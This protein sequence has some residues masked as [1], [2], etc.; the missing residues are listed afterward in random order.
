MTNDSRSGIAGDENGLMSTGQVIWSSLVGVVWEGAAHS[1]FSICSGAELGVEQARED[2]GCSFTACH[3]LFGWGEVLRG[4]EGGDTKLGLGLTCSFPPGV[5]I[6][7]FQLGLSIFHILPPAQTSKSG[8]MFKAMLCRSWSEYGTEG[9]CRGG[10]Q[11][12]QS[13]SRRVVFV[14]SYFS[15]QHSSLFPTLVTS[16]PMPSGNMLLP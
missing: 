13:Q 14:A 1:S 9:S 10:K 12:W 16:A 3:F 7:F 15:S 11:G 6:D 8:Y 5:Q 2:S 4:Q